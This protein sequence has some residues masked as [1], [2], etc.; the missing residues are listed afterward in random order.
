MIGVRNVAYLAAI[1]GIGWS[2][3]ASAAPV[4]IKALFMQ[5]AAYS[6][7]DVRNM[8]AGFEKLHP[9]IKVDLEFVAYEA[10][11]DKIVASEGSAGGGYDVVLFDDIWP[12]EFSQNNFLNDVT[13]LIPAETATTVFTGA[14]STVSYNGS[15]YG[16]PWILDTMY[17]FYNKA[18]LA[19]AGIAGPP[20]TWAELA[21]DAKI[22][23]A[24]NIVEYPI[25]WSWA[26][27]EALV[28]NYTTLLSAYGGS[29]YK[30]GKPV[31]DQDGGLEALQYMVQTVKEGL[32]NPKST[33]FVEDDVR[34]VI[35]NGDAAFALNWTYNYAS[36]KDPKQ[37]RVA[38]QIG[39]APAPG[40]AGK[41]EFAALNGSMGLGIPTNAGHPDQAWTYI[42][43]MTSQPVQDKYA[44]LSLPIWRSS[45]DNP[46]VTA[47]QEDLIAA[48]KY[49]INVQY[50][51]PQIADYQ[52]L[53][54]ILQ[55]DIQ[56]A[57]LGSMTPE[58]ALQD[59]AQQAR[60]LH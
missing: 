34:R 41:S 26:Q 38:G 15:R 16:M 18:M 52:H 56:K 45:Y 58:A 31:F 48:A 47:G 6:D 51:R 5:Q 42:L 59:A 1:V 12:A 55:K 39:V 24:K 14:W 21:D 57:L 29:F 33:E 11:H 27:A 37:S 35:D 13:K 22:L 53:S 10:L 20:K 2:I 25:V 54:A 40:I 7:T 19:K 44:Q 60:R 49:A 50:P 36:G 32:S 28:C 4:T 8:T 9:D 30:D 3:S 46:T 23:K 17:L 43:Y